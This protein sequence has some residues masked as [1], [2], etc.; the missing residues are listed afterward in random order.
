VEVRA[1]S[2]RDAGGRPR[3]SE[4][5]DG[6][7][8]AMAEAAVQEGRPVLLVLIDVSKTGLISPSPA[9][10]QALAAEHPGKVTVLVDACQLRLSG[11]SL[12]A[13]LAGGAMIAV[14]GSKFLTG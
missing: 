14:T 1:V 10:A 5:V 4:E 12:G 6:E 2:A 9:C 13:Y 11:P 8:R 3:G 7:V